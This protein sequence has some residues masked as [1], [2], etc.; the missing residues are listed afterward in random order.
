MY[1][2]G[3]LKPTWV[4]HWPLLPATALAA[5]LSLMATRTVEFGAASPR[6]VTESPGWIS[7]GKDAVSITGTLGAGASVAVGKGVLVC[8]GV[9]NGVLVGEGVSVATGS[10]VLVG[11]G[12][13]VSVAVAVGATMVTMTGSETA[14]TAD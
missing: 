1:V 8:V 4:R 12:A 14:T 3:W 5:N 7:A 11:A 2:P 9:G 13:G 10:G 6:T